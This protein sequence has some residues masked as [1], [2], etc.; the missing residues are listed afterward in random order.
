V[1]DPGGVDEIGIDECWR[2]LACQPV[3]RVAVMSGQY[4][5]VL[6]VNYAVDEHAIVFR[7]SDGE[8]QNR[9]HGSKVAFEV[10]QIDPFQRTGWSV[11]VKG[12]AH[13]LNVRGTPDLAERSYSEGAAPWAPGERAYL[14]KI[15]PD[16]ITGRRIRLA[17]VVS[18]SDIRG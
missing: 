2:L 15:I 5:L 11:L 16:E 17:G 8:K 10:D 18:S 4:P 7:S 13:S 12:V 6:P 9:I 3:G 1:V 14:V